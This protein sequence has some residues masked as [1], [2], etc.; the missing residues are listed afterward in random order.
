M[1]YVSGTVTVPD[2][3]NSEGLLVRFVD[4]ATGV[5]A[6]AVVG[7]DGS[8]ELQHKGDAGVP[9]GSYKISVSVY[10]PQMSDKEYTE[11]LSSPPA[12]RKKVEDQR[13]GKL[14]LVPEKY[15]SAATSGLSYEIISGSQ[16]HDIVLEK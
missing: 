8:Y 13:N 6:T 15:R 14:E 5:G 11:F 16:V 3:K 4:S 2:N 1:G 12:E 9:V 10:A 7:D